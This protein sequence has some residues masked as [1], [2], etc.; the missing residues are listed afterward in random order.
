MPCPHCSR[1]ERS[2]PARPE[3]S[4]SRTRRSTSIRRSR[5]AVSAVDVATEPFR[6]LPGAV[7][8]PHPV[9]LLSLSSSSHG[10]QTATPEP[11]RPFLHGDPH[12]CV[13]LAVPTPPPPAGGPR[14]RFNHDPPV[15]LSRGSRRVPVTPPG[16]FCPTPHEPLVVISPSP[17]TPQCC[18]LPRCCCDVTDH[19]DRARQCSSRLTWSSVLDEGPCMQ[20]SEFRR[21]ITPLKTCGGGRISGQRTGSSA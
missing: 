15:A 20:A 16:A 4:V 6:R 5:A 9:A 10:A 7:S 17:D 8:T 14:R 1:R 12:R 2:S 21:G 19:I 11:P 13:A 18:A 3:C